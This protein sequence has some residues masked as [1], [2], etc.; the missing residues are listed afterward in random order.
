MPAPMTRMPTPPTPFRWRPCRRRFDGDHADEFR[1]RRCRRDDVYCFGG[2]EPV[3]KLVADLV[4]YIGPCHTPSWLGGGEPFSKPP[5]GDR[6]PACD[7]P[8]SADSSGPVG[9]LT[10]HRLEPGLLLRGPFRDLREPEKS[11]CELGAVLGSH[12]T[13]RCSV[14][15][16]SLASHWIC[17]CWIS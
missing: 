3:A 4:E 10:T 17:N 13:M 15:R 12:R 2:G 16:V 8:E 6:Y 11:S 5:P 7:Q 9:L 14:N 1:C